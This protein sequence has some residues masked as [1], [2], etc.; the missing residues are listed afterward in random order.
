MPLLFVA[1]VAVTCPHASDADSLRGTA[2]VVDGDSIVV[3]GQ[4]VHIL[5]VGAPED[6][7]L[8]FRKAQAIEQGA[9]RCGREAAAALADWIG[10]QTVTCDTTGRG[11][12]KAWL[13]RC[14]VAGRDLG[15]WL[16]AEGWAVPS[17]HRKCEIVRD[18]ADKARAARLGIWSRNFTMPWVWRNAH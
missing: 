9:R 1:I 18:A 14:T 6:A 16:A 15:E 11:I 10:S 2:R 13:A 8:C 7:Q 12:R 17:L 4:R 3:D 5:D